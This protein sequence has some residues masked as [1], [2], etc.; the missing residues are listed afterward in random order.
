MNP[1]AEEA[2]GGNDE[3]VDDDDEDDG[4]DDDD[5]GDN[6]MTGGPGAPGALGIP[7][8]GPH[9]RNGGKVSRKRSGKE[10]G[11]GGRVE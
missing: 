9:E 4:D 3:D 11:G 7:A 10:E 1:R 6:N 5:D 8:P 2:H